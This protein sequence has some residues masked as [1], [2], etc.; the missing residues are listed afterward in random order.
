MKRKQFALV[1]FFVFLFIL[2]LHKE[3]KSADFYEH[4]LMPNGFGT[5]NDSANSLILSPLNRDCQKICQRECEAF[6]RKFK[7][8][9]ILNPTS[10]YAE[11]FSIE[12]NEDVIL[13]CY[14]KCQKGGDDRFTS[15][16]FEAFRA[17]CDDE[18][19]QNQDIFQK[20]CVTNPDYNPTNGCV[21]S[22]ACKPDLKKGYIS[23]YKTI[24]QDKASVG[25]MCQGTEEENAYNVI[26]TG[27]EAKAG[28]KFSF[29]LLGGASDNQLYLCG[30]KHIEITPIF[31]NI[32]NN[33]WFKLRWKNKYSHRFL[34]T[35]SDGQFNSLKDRSAANIYWNN[36]V[37]N[38]FTYT[39]TG[40]IIDDQKALDALQA[41]YGA[42]EFWINISG[43]NYALKNS[44]AGWG[45]KNPNFLDTG[46]YLR[47]TDNLTIIWEG[48][49]TYNQDIQVI[50][51]GNNA[52]NSTYT[53]KNPNRQNKNPNRQNIITDCIWNPNIIDPSKCID[54]WYK[55]SNLAIKDPSDNSQSPSVTSQDSILE[56]ECFRK[57]G[58]KN[59]S[60]TS[61]NN[62]SS[63][64]YSCNATS[65]NPDKS[66]PDKSNDDIKCEF[67]LHGTIIDTGV[68]KEYLKGNVDLG[69]GNNINCACPDKD[70]SGDTSG[71]TSGCK[72]AYSSYQCINKG[73]FDAGQSKYILQGSFNN[74][75]FESR[76]KLELRHF[77]NNYDDASG[78]YSLSIDWAGCPKS[79]M[80]NIQY[81]IAK[82]GS[83]IDEKWK[84]WIDVNDSI[85]KKD[86]NNPD[87]KDL[88]FLVISGYSISDDCIQ[89]SK[90]CKIF[91]RIKLEKPDDTA[92]QDLK[93]IYKYNNTFGQYYVNLS[94][95]GDS[96]VCKSGGL[97]YDTMKDI[98]AVLVGKDNSGNNSHLKY[99]IKLNNR[100]DV[101]NFKEVDFKEVG[102][103]GVVYSGFVK[104]AAYVIK[105]I[106]VLYLVFFAI[107]YMLGL[108]D[109]TTQGFIKY[110]MKFAIVA[111]LIS[112]TSW[113]FFGGYLVSFFIDGSIE[114]VA[115]YSASFL[116]AVASNQE[117]CETMIIG[118]PFV[119]FSIFNGPIYQFIAADTWSRIW[120]ICTNGLLG[121]VTACFLIF[122]IFHYFIAIVKA[123]VMFMFAIIINSIL[124]VTAPVFI[125]CI[126]FEKTKQMFD[127]W[128]KNLFSYALQPLFV[129]TSIIILNY[130]ITI[131]IYYIFNFT[132]C[133]TCLV[134]VDLGPL[135]N[136]C[137]VSGYNSMLDI[138][139]PPNESG[140]VSIYSAFASYAMTFIGGLV[141]YLVAK[142]MSEFSSYMSGIASWI[143]TGSPMR[144]M[145]IGTVEDSASKFVEAKAKQAAIAGATAAV[146][147]ATAGVGMA[148]GGA[149]GAGGAGAAGG[150]VTGGGVTGGG[151]TGGGVTGGGVTGGGVTGGGV[152][153]GGV[154]GGGVTGGGVTGGGVTGG[155]VTGGGVTG[156]TTSKVSERIAENLKDKLK[157]KAIDKLTKDDDD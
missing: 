107:S 5:G 123:T 149:G 144:H 30:K 89:D 85:V 92:D 115:R 68:D 106:L 53:I 155:G 62:N 154:T 11:T 157:E 94:K 64:G 13:N 3:A 23:F 74:P 131:L 140:T 61:P 43:D 135:Y 150:G 26:E 91:L 80:N 56:G 134:R 98:K 93:E 46:I 117:T 81:T 50:K 9:K 147:V 21:S 29:N 58:V 95:K 32:D 33:N 99:D 139:S 88:G 145:S 66:N 25:M 49:Y 148:A 153:G 141:I 47:N 127:S 2:F 65:C 28:D 100:G 57:G 10:I 156:N 136:E 152:T 48:D 59:F 71:D 105:I 22:L 79:K 97:I 51:V 90:D 113:N 102:A 128:A 38:Q 101:T 108:V 120:A 42:Q 78:G 151:V 126:L 75:K 7:P 86:A 55:N 19:N 124:I 143:A 73:T 45:A 112:D 110:L 39:K 138:H 77:Y 36:I 82:K 103:V 70:A 1:V 34:A 142:G 12:L 116:K 24:Q 119:I 121:F 14:S 118:D 37:N 35:L 104:K 67:G 132:A 130:I 6:S 96:P 44:R 17:S 133:S 87:Q 111:F 15:N 69:N 4:C 52:S 84:K 72:N 54:R 125:V 129:Y 20:I 63:D 114:L 137:W 41:I 31:D 40:N 83:H 146:A 76:S 122:A 16:Y 18:K 27:F 8:Y 109:Y 60:I